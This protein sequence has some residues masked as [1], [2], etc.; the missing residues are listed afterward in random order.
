MIN[1]VVG[2][3]KRAA[4][5]TKHKAHKLTRSVRK[6]HRHIRTHKIG[7]SALVIALVAILWLL[8]AFAG[9]APGQLGYAIKRGEESI[10]S[11]LAPLSSW[12]NAL[13]LDFANN[14]VSEAAYVAN[15]ANENGD[16]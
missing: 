12:R 16:Q 9:A 4:H 13:R 11:N 1:K 6:T 7:A 2:T 15:Q 5:S 14:R 3:T 10:A 8:P